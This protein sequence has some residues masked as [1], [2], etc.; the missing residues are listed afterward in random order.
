MQGKDASEQEAKCK[1][2]VGIDVCEA[3]LDIHI[4]PANQAL[5]V[6]NTCEGHRTLKRRLKRYD[7]GLI[8]IEATGKWH[9]QLHRSLHASGYQVRVVNPLRARLFA[10]GMGVLAKTDRLDAHMLAVFAGNLEGNARPPAPE[11]I[12]DL[13]ELVQARVSAVE[14]QTSLTN[15]LKSA[16]TVFLRRQLK[17]RLRHTAKVIAE[18]EAE[19]LRRVKADEALAHRY[20]ILRSVPSFGPVVAI[21]LLAR[22]P[23]L[24]RCNDKQIATLTGLAPWPDD[25]GLREGPRHIRGGRDSVRHVL[26]LAALTATRCNRDMKAFFRRLIGAGKLTK[27]ALIA[28]ARKLVVLANTLIIEDRLWLPEPPKC[29]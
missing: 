18:I 23:E 20:E 22:L 10:E 24:G 16:Q 14:E 17:R 5:R 26:Y 7:V 2:S 21:T 29:A 19:L 6:P 1:S 25:S 28:V 15:Q 13:K 27:V 4:L 12:E 3:W 11:V 8:A 9:R